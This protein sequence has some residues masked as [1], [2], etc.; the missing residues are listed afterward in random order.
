MTNV[1]VT[2]AAGFIGSHLVDKLIDNGYKVIGIDDLSGGD[3]NNVN[4]KSKF[5]K[6][7]VR[8]YEAAELIFN[9]YKPEIVFHLAANAAENKAQFSPI[10][11]T[12]R[13]YDAFIKVLTSGIR[14]GMKKIIV[15]SS[16]AVYGGIP[17]PFRETDLPKPEDLYGISKLAM[18]QTIKVMSDVHGFD[19]VIVRPHNVFGPR[20]NMKDPYRNV[21][22]LF[23]NA[24]LKNEKYYIYGDGNQNRCFTYVD[25]VV[26]AIYKCGTDNAVSKRIFNLGADKSYTVN[27]LS[28]ELQIISKIKNEPIYLHS[29][30]QEVSIAISDHS[31]SKKV[32]KYKD[33]VSFKEG[34][35]RTWAWAKKNGPQELTYTQMEIESEKIPSNWIKNEKNK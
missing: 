21:V 2:G 30:P 27:Q 11:I 7:D 18:E 14:N 4:P 20:Q 34:L 31:L 22:T 32:L 10:D 3:M 25:G 29:R 13:N 6:V 19:W 35:K 5:Y 33:K 24:L 16:I 1:L 9:L 23:I 15:T 28:S 8:N 26:N 12:S 17:T